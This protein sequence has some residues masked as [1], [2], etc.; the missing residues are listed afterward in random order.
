MGDAGGDG[1]GDGYGEVAG[2][3]GGDV[4]GDDAGDICGGEGESSLIAGKSWRGL[5][6]RCGE[7]ALG[8]AAAGDAAERAMKW[9]GEGGG[10]VGRDIP[11]MAGAALFMT[12][13]RGGGE[14]TR[15]AG[16]SGRGGEGR[17][18]ARGGVVSS[19]GDGIGGKG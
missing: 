5:S 3:H 15:V 13:G 7:R 17:V 2:D 19:A 8:V 6:L 18:G 4:G 10:G 16:G 12:R 1:G 14:A 11:V 9:I